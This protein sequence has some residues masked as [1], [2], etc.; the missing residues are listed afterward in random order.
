MSHVDDPRHPPAISPAI[1]HD[2]ARADPLVPLGWR[3]GPWEALLATAHPGTTPGRVVRQDRTAGSVT[4]SAGTVRVGWRPHDPVPV[5]GDWVALDMAGGATG[6]GPRVVGIAERRTAITRP[7]LAIGYRTAGADQVLAANPDLVAVVMSVEDDLRVRRLE[8]GLV[9]AYESGATPL[10]VL[11]KAD[12]CDD[13]ALA[14]RQA[15]AAA[16]GVEVV[17][18][19]AVTGAGTADLRAALGPDRT[20][21]M[22]GASGSGKSALTNALVQEEVMDTGQVRAMDL[23]GR[24]TTTHRELVVLPSGGAVLDTPGLRT[25]SLAQLTDGLDRAFPDVEELAGACRFR[26][27]RHDTEPGCAVAAAVRSRE[28]DADRLEG[29]RRIRAEAENAA[30]RAD[31]AAFRKAARSWGLVAREAQRLQADRRQR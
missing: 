22:L 3:S 13:V 31:R 19:S 25:L 5:T 17:V 30:L 4:T 15:T 29:W 16:P 18:T 20:V 11:S 10:V 12:L 1:S 7:A 28:L 14:V 26:D 24:H 21:A 9:L 6:D 2:A 23:R 8:R 27:C